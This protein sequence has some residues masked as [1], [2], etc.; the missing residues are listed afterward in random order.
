[1]S[2]VIQPLQAI[3]AL[4]ETQQTAQ[5]PKNTQAGAHSALPQDTVT[6]STSAKQALATNKLPAAGN[7]GEHGS[8]NQ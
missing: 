1:V 2:N 6:I 8:K 3:N 5:K 7:G 4:A